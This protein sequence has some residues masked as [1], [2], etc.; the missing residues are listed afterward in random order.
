MT[1]SSTAWAVATGTVVTVCVAGGGL[2]GLTRALEPQPTS[3]STLTTSHGVMT[4]STGGVTTE[5]TASRVPTSPAPPAAD[6][7]TGSPRGTSD[8][9]IVPPAAPKILDVSTSNGLNWT[10]S[11]WAD[12]N[13]DAHQWMHQRTRTDDDAR[14]SSGDP[15]SDSWIMPST[16][17]PPETPAPALRMTTMQQQTDQQSYDQHRAPGPRHRSDD[18]GA[19]GGNFGGHQAGGSHGRHR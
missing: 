5:S 16:E 15:T 19:D 10:E 9:T 13:G 2:V 1:K 4:K 17:A 8:P 3:T 18:R 11:R 12:Y 14:T 6:P 7:A